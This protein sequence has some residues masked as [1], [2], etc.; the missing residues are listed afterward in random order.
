MG[1]YS[2]AVGMLNAI[3]GRDGWEGKGGQANSPSKNSGWR[4]LEEAISK[5]EGP[6]E[7]QICSETH[8]NFLLLND[9]L[10]VETNT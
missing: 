2:S 1:K 8:P 6:G 9:S 5:A 4:L 10:H 7:K 3:S